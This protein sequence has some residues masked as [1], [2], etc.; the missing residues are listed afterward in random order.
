MRNY[1][2]S[3]FIF[4]FIFVLLPLSYAETINAKQIILKSVDTDKI[5]TWRSKNKIELISKSG[6]IRIRKGISI[7]KLQNGNNYKRFYKF[8]YPFDVKGTTILTIEHSDKNDD[9]WI[10]LPALKKTRRLVGSAKKDS[11]MGTDFSYGD[12]VSFKVN[13]FNHLFLKTDVV[14]NIDCYVITSI[15]KNEEIKNYTGYSKR[16][17]WVRKDNFF[18]IRIVYYDIKGNLL[19]EQVI[20]DLINVDPLQNKWLA[21]K[22][23]MINY[24]TGYKTIIYLDDVE[25]NIKIDDEFFSQ[26]YMERE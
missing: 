20:S 19:K 8:L 14:D 16:I 3:I 23:E 18:T 26:R 2:Y 12:V 5:D 11:F 24:Q 13:D 10:Y 22:R 9:M 25:T 17:A 21:K 6:G 1:Q 4:L 7:N 15:P